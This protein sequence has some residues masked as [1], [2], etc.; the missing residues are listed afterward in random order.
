MCIQDSHTESFMSST[1]RPSVDVRGL[2][3]GGGGG[4]FISVALQPHPALSSPDK[5]RPHVPCSLLSSLINII[6]KKE[7]GLPHCVLTP[8][9]PLCDGAFSHSFTRYFSVGLLRSP[10][11]GLTP[12][13][14]NIV[15]PQAKIWKTPSLPCSLCLSACLFLQHHFKEE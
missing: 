2:L 8:P 15:W 10:W 3:G 1:Y 13:R 4:T 11:M 5:G 6:R 7:G 9:S 12:P 14:G